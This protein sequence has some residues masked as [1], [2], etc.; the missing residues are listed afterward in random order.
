[1]LR[2]FMERRSAQIGLLIAAF[3][4]TAA[5]FGNW[6][7]RVPP[8]RMNPEAKL[9]PPSLSHP[10]GADQF[11]RD[12]LARLLDGGRRSLGAA[13][14]VLAGV[15][16]FSLIAGIA[17]G[18]IGGLVE[19]ILMRLLDVLLAMPSMVL[20]LAVVGVM[21]VGYGNLLL[22][23]VASSWAYYARLA[24]SCVRVVR[25]RGDVVSARLAGIGWLR[26]ASGHI[27]P[28]VARQLIIVATL[29]LG[30]VIIWI[31]GLSF[32]GL[33]VQPPDAEWGAMLAESRLYFTVAPWLLCAPA[34]AIFLAVLAANL[35]GNA[36]RDAAE[37]QSGG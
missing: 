3:L 8:E 21:G 19:Q 15:L 5:L 20:A 22:A 29:D 26:V 11:G 4:C 23:L 13:L 14:T 25:M 33:G 27:V 32:L 16:L 37:V 35:I 24:R 17:A 30:S 18:M 1:M 28:G 7:W 9:A 2:R 34:S 6:I 31:A 12:Q 36:L 10:L